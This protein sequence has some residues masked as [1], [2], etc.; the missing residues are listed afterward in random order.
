MEQ[1]ARICDL[2]L[3][4]SKGRVVYSG[5]VGE[6]VTTYERINED[7]SDADDAFISTQDPILNFSV[8]S[9][10]IKAISCENYPFSIK[11]E[12]SAYTNSFLLRIIFYS[13]AGGYA[14]D[15]TFSSESCGITI[16][17]GVNR[18]KIVIGS[19][20]L[21]NGRYRIAINVIDHSGNLIVWS[22]KQHIVEIT[23]AYVGAIADCQLPLGSWSLTQSD[24]RK[25][26][27]K[28]TQN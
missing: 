16:C 8:T 12:S 19:L 15:C 21:K 9:I 3:M 4:L 20:A 22:Y 5:S 1:V 25:P 24:S 27:D 7:G 2:A 28:T 26:I 23:G 13:E 18:W 17:P 6:G 14:A 11:I 10:P